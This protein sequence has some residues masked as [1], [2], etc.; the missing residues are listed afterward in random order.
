MSVVAPAEISAPSVTD[1][2]R[3]LSNISRTCGKQPQTATV[4]SMDC[5]AAFPMAPRIAA[6]RSTFCVMMVTPHGTSIHFSRVPKPYVSR[7]FSPP[8][9]CNLKPT[10]GFG[11]LV[12]DPSRI[13]VSPALGN[14]RSLPG[15][16]VQPS[17]IRL[18]FLHVGQRYLYFV[19]VL[20]ESV[21]R[22][23]IL[24]LRCLLL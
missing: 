8:I 13:G 23:W 19:L 20:Q 1:L 11:A 18:G 14:I 12:A 15:T 16:Q 7:F 3:S 24:A 6:Q 9:E 22:M 4:F 5:W 2:K 21:W 17:H 10:P